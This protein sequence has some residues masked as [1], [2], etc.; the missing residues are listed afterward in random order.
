MRE[1]S[2]ML[3]RNRINSFGFATLKRSTTDKENMRIANMES[4]LHRMHSD[5]ENNLRKQGATLISGS[6]F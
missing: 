4:I 3:I 5:Y 6:R 1:L 2:P